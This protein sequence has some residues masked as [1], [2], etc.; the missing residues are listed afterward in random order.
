MHSVTC[1][2]SVGYTVTVV[3]GRGYQIAVMQQKQQE[4]SYPECISCQQSLNKSQIPQ[5][6]TNSVFN[7]SCQLYPLDSKSN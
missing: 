2:M 4:T 5:Q 3:E 7:V 6:T 1:S